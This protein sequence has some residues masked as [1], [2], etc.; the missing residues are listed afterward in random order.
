MP[1]LVIDGHPDARSLTAS[2]AQRYAAGH[3]DAR[4]LALRDL[5][6]DPSLRFG[7][8]ERMTLEPDLVE[9]KRA[10]QEADTVVIATPLWWGS[11]PALLKGFFDR[12]LLPQQEYRYN[13]LGLVDGLLPARHGRLLLLADTP[14]YFV[15][16]TGLPAQTHV[17]RGTMRFCGIRSVRTHRMLG[18]KDATPATID[19]WLDHA[20]RLGAADGRRDGVRQPIAAGSQPIAAEAASSSVVATS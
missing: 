6:F 17:A 8:R 5:D 3:G 19:R 18:V 2:L 4:V 20:E 14:W 15:P 9:A 7:Y 16:F 13:K 1:A 11:V 10:L 12:A